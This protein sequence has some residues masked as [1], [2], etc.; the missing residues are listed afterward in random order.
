MLLCVLLAGLIEGVSMKDYR[1]NYRRHNELTNL[2][3]FPNFLPNDLP[4]VRL[5]LFD[6]FAQCYRLKEVLEG[7]DN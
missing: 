4:L 3:G 7:C 1:N 2:R 6:R 5:V